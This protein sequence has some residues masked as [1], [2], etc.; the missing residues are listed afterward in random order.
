MWKWTSKKEKRGENLKKKKW[1]K[2]YPKIKETQWATCTRNEENYDKL[3]AFWW[4]VKENTPH[5]LQKSLLPKLN[6]I[7]V[8]RYSPRNT[9]DRIKIQWH[10]RIQ[11]IKFRYGKSIRRMTLIL[12]RMKDINQCSVWRLSGSWYEQT[13]YKMAFMR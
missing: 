5:H 9:G 8:T 13:K 12:Q 2:L 6:L 10:Y 4:D 7:L 3:S 1:L 11:S